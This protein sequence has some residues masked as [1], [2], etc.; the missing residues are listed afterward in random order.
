[1]RIFRNQEIVP[2]LTFHSVGM[3]H[4]TW[5]WKHLS[6]RAD[7]FER[8][9][10]RLT[11]GGY[12]TVSL[13]QLYA[14][15]SGERS[16]PP[17]SIV[18]VF[19]DGYLD[20]WLTVAPLLKKY[21]LQGVVYVNPEFVD[22]STGLRSM[23][24]ENESDILAEAARQQRGFMNWD[25]LR[26]VDQDGVLDVQS[27]SLTH[28]WHFTGPTVVDCYV[29]G[30]A[31]EYPWMQWN[32]K[33]DRKPHYLTENQEEFVALGTPI[34]EFE[35]SLLARRFFPDDELVEEVRKAATAQESKLVQQV[36]GWLKFYRQ[37]IVDVTGVEEFPGHS[38]SVQEHEARVRQ[39]LS[40]SKVLIEKQL[41]KTVDYL[42]WPGG[43]TDDV[44]KRVAREVGYKSWTLPSR[45]LVSKRNIQ[46]CEPTEM[47][48][49]P[50][51]RENR[52]LGRKWGECGEVLV[53]L[54]VFA[55]QDSALFNVARKFYKVAA[56]AHLATRA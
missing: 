8:L 30:N 32:S 35:K 13:D 17:K 29:P 37:L 7:I 31:H 44:A 1:M 55:H 2:I 56:A 34:F 54:D 24:V 26:A 3:Q 19:D 46:N 16:C 47:K 36:P 12:R 6:E 45:E 28:T 9:L 51:S 49:L 15:M 53:L 48:R 11:T 23:D 5:I 20:N 52:F 41:N 39:E 43:G 21:S 18:L 4:D 42:C 40:E 10:Q 25:E 50:A 33:P 14:H 38:E 22:Q 27:H